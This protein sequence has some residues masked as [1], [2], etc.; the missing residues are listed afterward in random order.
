MLRY[1]FYRGYYLT[2]NGTIANDVLGDLDLHFQGQ[3]FSC[4]VFAIKNCAGSG[5]PRQICFDS[6]GLRRGVPI[7]RISLKPKYLNTCYKYLLRLIY[8]SYFTSVTRVLI[9]FVFCY[10]CVT[11]LPSKRFWCF[12]QIRTYRFN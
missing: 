7:V 6:H 2:S 9:T 4:H 1:D 8:Y 11:S 5:C 10:S 12:K 3:T